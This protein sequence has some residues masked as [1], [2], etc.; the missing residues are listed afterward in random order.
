MSDSER[1]FLKIFSLFR[2]EVT[3]DDFAIVFRH[4]VKGTEFN[5]VL[6]RMHEFDF[7]DLISGLV[8]WRLI[9]YDETKNTYT[10]HPLIKGYFES[11]FDEKIKKLCHKHIYQYFGLYALEWPETLEEM[12]PLFEQVYHGCAAG[13]YDEVFEDIYWVKIHRRD[14]YFITQKLG[15]WET[16]LS[17]VKTFF[18]EGDLS[19]M[20]LVSKKGNQSWL[21]SMKQ[22]WYFFV[23]AGQKRVETYLLEE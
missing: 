3:E 13:F 5:D 12:Q 2:Q 18:P 10:T 4:K 19:Q 20:S 15:A 21:L 8:D 22:D 7:R 23:Q 6:V 14:K 17:L 16:A 9:S 11:T 1:I